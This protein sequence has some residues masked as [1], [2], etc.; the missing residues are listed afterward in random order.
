MPRQVSS[1][2]LSNC[3]TVSRGASLACFW[4]AIYGFFGET[5]LPEMARYVLTQ[6]PSLFGWGGVDTEAGCFLRRLFG[7]SFGTIT[8]SAA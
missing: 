5:V 7:L 1:I 8:L 2:T 4:E 3:K 6:Y